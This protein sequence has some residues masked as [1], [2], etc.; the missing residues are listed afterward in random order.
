MTVARGPA[1][2]NQC[3][4]PRPEARFS[5]EFA[6]RPRRAYDMTIHCVERNSRKRGQVRIIREDVPDALTDRGRYENGV[7]EVTERIQPRI[8]GLRMQGAHRRGKIEEGNRPEYRP[9]GYLDVTSDSSKKRGVVI[10]GALTNDG[11]KVGGWA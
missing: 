10:P 5:E 4:I 2:V 7:R 9:Y 1:K 11:V 3:E 8:A 6:G